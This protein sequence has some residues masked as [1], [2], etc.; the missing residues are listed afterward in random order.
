MSENSWILSGV[1]SELDLFPRYKH[2]TLCL[3]LSRSD[4]SGGI[5]RGSWKGP[6]GD[7]SAQTGHR[8]LWLV[9]GAAEQTLMPWTQR[10]GAGGGALV[11][12]PV[13]P[14]LQTRPCWPSVTS[15]RLVST[16]KYSQETLIRCWTVWSFF[17]CICPLRWAAEPS[18]KSSISTWFPLFWE[19]SH[20]CFAPSDRT[21]LHIRTQDNLRFVV[22]IFPCELS[23][24]F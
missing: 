2:D 5:H 15:S 22:L 13:L 17:I 10:G 7:G 4:F 21:Q 12:C 16:Q 8:A 6:V 14:P 23:W 24:F 1:G 11:R 18:I 9:H 3:V 20:V 19:R